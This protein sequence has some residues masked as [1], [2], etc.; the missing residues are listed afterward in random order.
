MGR[1]KYTR[2]HFTD[3]FFNSLDNNKALHRVM[4]T[5]DKSSGMYWELISIFAA[6]RL[7]LEKTKIF[8]TFI[9][10]KYRTDI[11]TVISERNSFVRDYEK[12]IISF[13]EKVQH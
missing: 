5:G 8:H 4:N 7:T 2:I 3:G 1:G 13:Y 9:P 6:M 12:K 10:D 11:K